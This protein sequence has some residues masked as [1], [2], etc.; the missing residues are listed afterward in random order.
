MSDVIKKSCSNCE[1]E[2][3]C[4]YGFMCGKK[5]VYWKP[6]QEAQEEIKQIS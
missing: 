2:L 5:Y 1:Y 4:G 6:D 3:E